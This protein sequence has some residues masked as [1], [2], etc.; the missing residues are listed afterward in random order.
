MWTLGTSYATGNGDIRWMQHGEEA[1]AWSSVTSGVI[2][3]TAVEEV[4]V[5][6][7]WT[8]DTLVVASTLVGVSDRVRV[9]AI[10]PG[11]NELLWTYESS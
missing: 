4:A 3:A 1:D 5:D 9:D 11:T 10:R 2:H 6:G 7:V 8:G